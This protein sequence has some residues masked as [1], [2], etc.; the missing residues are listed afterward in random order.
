MVKEM[1][2][3]DVALEML[4]SQPR[5]GGLT[6]GQ[7]KLAEAQAADYK[8]Q[9]GEIKMLGERMTNLEK[10]MSAMEEEQTR[11]FDNIEKQMSELKTL[12]IEH[13]KRTLIDIILELKDHK[14]FWLTMIII[15]LVLAA[16]FGVPVTGFNG[17]LSVGG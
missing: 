7:I 10:K 11:R 14:Y 6:A 15:I 3:Q 5:K 4:K 9:K 17:I 13:N 12:I 8:S 2:R 16:L 1:C